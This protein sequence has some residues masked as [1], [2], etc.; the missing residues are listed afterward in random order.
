[1]TSISSAFHEWRAQL[2]ELRKARLA[3]RQQRSRDE[4]VAKWG[5]PK[6]GMFVRDVGETEAAFKERIAKDYERAC[7]WAEWSAAENPD[8]ANLVMPAVFIVRFPR[9]SREM[10]EAQNEKWRLEA[11]QPAPAA[12]S[13][14]RPPLPAASRGLRALSASPLATAGA[15][16]H[17]DDFKDD[18][19]VEIGVNPSP[20]LRTPPPA[21]AR[22]RMGRAFDLWQGAGGIAATPVD[23]A[24]FNGGKPNCFQTSD[25]PGALSD[26]AQAELQRHEI[27]FGR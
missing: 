19:V 12:L 22:P 23:P 20:G 8:G 13:A 11:P 25:R 1:M 14:P 27:F 9:W 10:A 15:P 17:A 26:L 24:I 3:H 16:D 18:P 21:A 5:E 4:M 7:A 6:T 2:A